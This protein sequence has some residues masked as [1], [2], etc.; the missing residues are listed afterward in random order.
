MRGAHVTAENPTLTRRASS[1]EIM[2][3]SLAG[4]QESI[5]LK[6]LIRLSSTAISYDPLYHHH[7]LQHPMARS[8]SES[9][10][11]H[12]KR[13]P[14]DE[15]RFRNRTEPL[16]DRL[17]PSCSEERNSRDV[18]LRWAPK[19]ETPSTTISVGLRRKK[20]PRRLS[21]LGSE[22]RENTRDDLQYPEPRQMQDAAPT[23]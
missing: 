5:S 8:V 1:S 15:T 9:S 13:S 12:D 7:M 18:C 17:S 3:V 4:N 19:K 10:T 22:E 20:L 2:L 21:P 6:Q 16:L 14:L 11:M 23:Q